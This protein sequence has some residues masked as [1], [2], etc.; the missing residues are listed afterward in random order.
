MTLE[1]LAKRV[2]TE[3]WGFVPNRSVK[4]VHFAN[5]FFRSLSGRVGNPVLLHRAAGG[6]LKGK[7]RTSTEALRAD[8]AERLDTTH[9]T[10]SIERLKTLRSALDLVLGQDR[11]L[12]PSEKAYSFTLTHWR[13]SSSDASDQRTGRFLAGVLAQSGHTEVIEVL[14]NVLDRDDDAIYQLTAPLLDPREMGPGVDVEPDEAN[15][16][17]KLVGRSEPLRA[18][19]QAIVCLA[20]YAPYL[21]KSAFLHR[22]VTLCGFG[23]YHH[24][25][26]ATAEAQAGSTSTPGPIS[27]GSSSG[28]VS[29]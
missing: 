4:P 6:Y 2:A 7:A 15:R 28:A 16:L 13:H 29:W 12:F 9:G 19:A 5:G 14:R 18:T 27:R 17:A 11:A 1:E 21:E 3:T 10:P 22:L 23:L 25:V 8:I 24:V 20:E 26:N